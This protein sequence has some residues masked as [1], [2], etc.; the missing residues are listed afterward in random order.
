MISSDEI[1]EKVLILLFTSVYQLIQLWGCV[2]LRLINHLFVF[3]FSQH[4]LIKTKHFQQIS[5][6]LIFILSSNIH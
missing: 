5:L 3:T 1:I 4:L 6:K 2:K